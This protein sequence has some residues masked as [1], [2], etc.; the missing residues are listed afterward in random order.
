M[1]VNQ[2]IALLLLRLSLG[3]MFLYAG[4]TKIINPS[5]SAAG[6]LENAKTFSGFYRWLAS[7]SLLPLVNLVNEW[8]LALIGAAMILGLF[9][10]LS[11]AAGALLM[12]L[13]YFPI[14][15]FPYPNAHA[16]IVDEHIVYAAAF[17]VLGAMR[18]GRF[19]GLGP[20]CAKLPLCSRYPKLRS[21]VE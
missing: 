2:K 14:L 10:R 16:L 1:P 19:Y 5:W 3:V 13:Y 11:S 20:W 21:W 6:Y 7:G 4:V 8:G 17:L 9:I 12:L 15:S 18:T